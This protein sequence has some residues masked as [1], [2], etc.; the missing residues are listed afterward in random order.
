MKS[1]KFCNPST[2]SEYYL[3]TYFTKC[4]SSRHRQ[5]YLNK[6]WVCCS[7]HTENSFRRIEMKF[8]GNSEFYERTGCPVGL[9]R[10]TRVKIARCERKDDINNNKNQIF[11]LSCNVQT[12]HDQSLPPLLSLHSS[13]IPYPLVWY[14]DFISGSN[15]HMC[16][17]ESW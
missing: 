3:W 6:K 11:W 13:A 14:N 8:R 10:E 4:P 5:K 12:K 15:R 17:A 16:V 7:C 1:R 9:I 2:R